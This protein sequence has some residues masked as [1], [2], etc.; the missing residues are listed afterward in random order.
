MGR[1]IPP[2][3]ASEETQI[4]TQTVSRVI[5]FLDELGGEAVKVRDS[6]QGERVV[7][8]TDAIVERIRTYEQLE[9]SNTVVTGTGVEG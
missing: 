5:E 1:S 4:Y 9:S 7:V 2:L 3:T 8:F 6:Q